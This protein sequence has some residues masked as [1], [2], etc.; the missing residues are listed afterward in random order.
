MMKKQKEFAAT[1][2]KQTITYRNYFNNQAKG[3][4]KCNLYL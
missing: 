4:G 2:K 1:E 3:K